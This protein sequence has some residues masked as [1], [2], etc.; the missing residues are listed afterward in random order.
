MLPFN[1]VLFQALDILVQD[2]YKLKVKKNSEIQN[3]QKIE[4][5]KEN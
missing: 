2:I 3:Y 1:S 5:L 4:K